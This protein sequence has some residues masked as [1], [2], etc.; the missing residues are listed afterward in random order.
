MAS[1]KDSKN[2]ERCDHCFN[3]VVT[4]SPPPSTF[5]RSRDG[6]DV[7]KAIMEHQR[8]LNSS[9]ECDHTCISREENSQWALQIC[10]YLHRCSLPAEVKKCHDANDESKQ[11]FYEELDALLC[12]NWYRGAERVEKGLRCIANY[13]RTRLGDQRYAID[14]HHTADKLICVLG[15]LL[16]FN[17][18]FTFAEFTE[19]EEIRTI[20]EIEKIVPFTSNTLTSDALC[21][22][23]FAVHFAD[24]YMFKS[25]EDM[26][27]CSKMA[28]SHAVVPVAYRLKF[29]F[30]TWFYTKQLLKVTGNVTNRRRLKESMRTA[31]IALLE[32]V[33]DE[34]PSC[35]H[36]RLS[37]V[38]RMLFTVLGI[39]TY[40][41]NLSYYEI[42]D[43]DISIAETLLKKSVEMKD[44]FN[45]WH[46]LYFYLAQAKFLSVT[47]NPS[48]ST[49]L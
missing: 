9:L 46:A 44:S 20:R 14:K 42:P 8:M 37:L 2:T 21:C 45:P 36:E 27:M 5:E 15:E 10:K 38:Q 26:L 31:Q 35:E 3:E 11:R 48:K 16:E 33:F 43:E 7:L 29:C 24:K 6:V 1:R 34:T 28:L 30:A 13:Y 39:E 22:S 40:G 19:S 49:L 25:A 17:C 41:G 23:V 18:R 32:C 12:Q 4:C 47:G